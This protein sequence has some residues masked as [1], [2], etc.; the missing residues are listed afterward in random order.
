MYAHLY[1]PGNTATGAQVR[2]IV[3]LIASCTSSTAKSFWP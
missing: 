2:D 3:R 1:F